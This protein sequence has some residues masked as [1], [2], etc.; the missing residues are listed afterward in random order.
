[1]PIPAQFIDELTA[2]CD[3]ADVVGDYVPLTRK[4]GNLWGL[5][6]FHGEKTASFSVSPEK[7]IYHCF[8]CGKGGGVINF[9][10]EIENLPFPDAVRL[11][12]KRVNLEVP[13]ERGNADFRR[14]R[15]R[16]L[17]LNKE[18]ARFFHAKL[19]SP[20]GAAGAEYLYGKRKLSKGIVT[21]FGL[22][23]A[24]DRWDDLI[25]AMAAKGYDKGELLDAGLVVKGQNGRIY[26]RFRNRVMFPI[27]DLRGDVIGFG[28]RVLDD[29]TPKYLNSPDTPVFN[30]GRNLFALN[31]AKKTK[32]GRIIL[33]EGYMDTISLHQAGFDC[34]V[35]SLGTALTPDHAQLLSRFTKEAV[36][37]YDG[38]GA[39]VSA[40]Q[41]AIP[42]LE[43]TGMKVK[44]LRM[45]G[46]KDP[47]E[48]IKKFGPEAFGKLLDQ[49]EN[50]IE[51]RIEQIRRK[52]ELT[53]DTQKVEFLKEAVGLIAG[54]HSPVER[55]IY[56]ARCAEMAGI[57][58]DAMGQEVKREL[59]QR[60]KKEKKQQARKD[61]T[62][63]IQLQPKERAFHYQNIRSARAEEGVIRMVVLDPELF[64]AA[65]ALDPERFSAPLLSK[66]FGLLRRRWEDGLSVNLAAL[67][68]ELESDEMSHLTR[69]VDQPGSLQNGPQAMADYIE[70]IETEADK[71]T[72][73][74]ESDTLLA[75]QKKMLEKKGYGGSIH[76]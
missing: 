41:R 42:I 59:A 71:R 67:A 37:A 62:P 72:A 5:C 43:K 9:V 24:P 60:I 61:L 34:A 68:G 58:A 47:D 26:D 52:F 18:A 57:S 70:I 27:I 32:L 66:V 49:S 44:V 14:K 7:Q 75:M 19:L 30:K 31:I 3:I 76:E 65:R 28:G 36:I 33:T 2:R 20:A 45:Q 21:R 50:H 51:Y 40:A 11:L 63:A 46:A 17:A 16:M 73:E 38:D 13:E 25:A 69:V 55:E 64:R 12:A 29:G 15:E 54:L 39:G 35:A 6:P 4:G 56:G 53:D 48:F 22:G 8:G 23:A 10:M 74:S 1:M